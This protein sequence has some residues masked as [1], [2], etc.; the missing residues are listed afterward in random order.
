VSVTMRAPRRRRME[1]ATAP[2]PQ[3]LYGILAHADGTFSCERWP[4][5]TTTKNYI[6]AAPT[7][8]EYGRRYI[9]KHLVDLPS[10]FSDFATSMREA[11]QAM[12]RA[13][14]WEDIHCAKYPE[15]HWAICALQGRDP[16]PHAETHR[17][18]DAALHALADL[19][20]APPETLV[21][22]RYTPLPPWAW[23]EV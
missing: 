5:R 14:Y 17:R 8:L 1:S 16:Y 15:H 19:A 13:R 20:V 18:E 12:V 3:Y 9:P 10:G 22:R 23:E 11:W 2:P 21:G 6:L 7:P 4:V